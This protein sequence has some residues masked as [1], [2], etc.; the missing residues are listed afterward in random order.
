MDEFIN[1]YKDV[2]V[3]NYANFKG[4]LGRGAFWRFVL[5]NVVIWVII[6]IIGG[7][8]QGV[9]LYILTGA[10]WL[11]LLVPSLAAGSRRLHDTGKS[12][13]FLLLWL[14]PVVGQIIVIVLWARE[15]DDG[16]NEYGPPYEPNALL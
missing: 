4:R 7:I 1:A 10:Y 16:A 9:I 15:G 8:F 11:A 5:V 14:I 2:V 12:A 3:W 6:G 13:W